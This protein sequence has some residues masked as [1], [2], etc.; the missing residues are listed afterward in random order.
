MKRR[1]VTTV[2]YQ[3]PPRMPDI[4]IAGRSIGLPMAH[5]IAG[6]SQFTAA[7]MTWHQHQGHE[8]LMMLQGANTYGF[9][10]NR[11]VELAGG[12]F[13]VIPAGT[14]HR[15]VHDVR[16]P[17][18]LCAIVVQPECRHP[19]SSPFTT[20]EAKWLLSKLGMQEPAPMPMPASMHRQARSLHRSIIG[21]RPDDVSIETKASLRLQAA[22]LM[23]EAARHCE[24]LGQ[25]TKE[26][27]SRKVIT[28]LEK[29]HA[30]P[31]S[32]SDL[33]QIAECSRARLF[34][35]FKSATGMSPN[36]WL[37]RYRIQRAAKLLVSTDR[38]L[39]AI[40]HSVGIASSAYFCRLF[41]KYMGRTPGE[42]RQANSDAPWTTSP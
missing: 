9:K 2:T 20:R 4:L 35:H 36:D 21:H 26:N 8:I 14:V 15:G 40:A 29:H 6:N 10:T 33:S 16:T 5:Y 22:M 41:R 39:D 25:E 37:L 3:S 28:Y 19:V 11:Q 32:I 23:L 27:L 17:S 7:P 12:H 38:K 18:I 24:Q 30:N 1:S 31:I 34:A 42:Y 13:M